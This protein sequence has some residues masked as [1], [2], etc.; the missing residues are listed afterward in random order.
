M[1]FIELEGLASENL[2]QTTVESFIFLV[3]LTN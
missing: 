1:V 3:V 2:H